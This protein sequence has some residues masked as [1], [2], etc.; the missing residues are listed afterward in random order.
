MEPSL[1]P[2]YKATTVPSTWHPPS[3]FTQQ[4]WDPCSHTE[5]DHIPTNLHAPT[6]KH[7]KYKGYFDFTIDSNAHTRIIHEL[8]KILQNK[9]WAKASKSYNGEGLEQGQPHLGPASCAHSKLLQKGMVAEAVALEGLVLNKS[10]C[11]HRIAAA[12]EES[13]PKNRKNHKDEVAFCERIRICNRCNGNYVDTSMHRYFLCKDN[14]NIEH[15]YVKNSGWLLKKIGSFTK[16]PCK[17]FR[18]ILPAGLITQAVDWEEYENCN[19]TEMGN[20]KETLA[21]GGLAG[22]DGSG[23]KEKDR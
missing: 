21:A 8:T 16:I 2:A 9:I 17:W 20:F 18:A 12:R 15:D 7:D 5:F 19:M 22:S 4:P 6:E 14:D 10:W 11:G 1:L 13:M 23:S 3:T